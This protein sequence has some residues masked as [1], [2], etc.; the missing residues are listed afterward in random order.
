M[1]KSTNPKDPYGT[2][3][4]E[5]RDFNDT[6]KNTKILES[7]PECNL[8]PGDENFIGKRVG[9]YKVYYNFDAETE[10]ERRLVVDGAHPNQ[11]LYVRVIINDSL[12][13]GDV[14][15]DALPFWF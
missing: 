10:S 8:N 4:V 12:K 11:S 3:T 13:D 6:D 15:K 7:F 9:D 2:F 5:I 14:P 1:K